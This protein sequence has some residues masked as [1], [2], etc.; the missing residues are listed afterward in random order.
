MW[1]TSTGKARELIRLAALRTLEAL[2]T[3]N[4]CVT[5]E[6]VGTAIM[7]FSNERLEDLA[8]EKRHLW[9]GSDHLVPRCRGWPKEFPA[10]RL[11]D[12]ALKVAEE[13]ESEPHGSPVYSWAA[14][15]IDDPLA[16]GRILAE[17]GGL[18][19]KANR[20]S[21]PHRFDLD[22]PKELTNDQ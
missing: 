11:D 2:A 8:S 22:S 15:Y 3:S 5:G 20:T 12:L 10:S 16:L 14:G 7:R 19:V 4:K 9:P 1:S 13:V 21:K 6:D 17:C 18:L